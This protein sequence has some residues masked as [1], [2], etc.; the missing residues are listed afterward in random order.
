MYVCLQVKY[1]SLLSDFKEN[2]IFSTGFSKRTQ[3]HNFI[4]MRPLGSGFFLAGERTE[5]HD[6]AN[7]RFSQFFQKAPKNQ[8]RFYSQHSVSYCTGVLISP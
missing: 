2:G 5:R 8:F 7:S 4:E 1:T 6:E 3:T